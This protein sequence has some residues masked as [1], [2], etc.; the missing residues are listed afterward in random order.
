MATVLSDVEENVGWITLN[1]PDAMN[2]I[3]IELAVDLHA[4]LVELAACAR[5]MCLVHLDG[6]L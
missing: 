2:A 5:V 3:T 1:R 6:P 4:A